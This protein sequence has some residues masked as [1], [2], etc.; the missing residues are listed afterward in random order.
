MLVVDQRVGISFIPT[1]NIHGSCGL[2]CG[3]ARRDSCWVVPAK[4]LVVLEDELAVLGF[5]SKDPLPKT[6][7]CPGRSDVW[8]VW[9]PRVVVYAGFA[10][11]SELLKERRHIK[12]RVE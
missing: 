6:S 12:E 7:G 8:A 11:S 3:D 5:G 9:A 2:S 1:V 10:K 4:R